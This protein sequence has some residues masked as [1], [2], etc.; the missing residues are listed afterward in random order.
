MLFSGLN[1]TSPGPALLLGTNGSPGNPGLVG[2]SGVMG[3]T[4]LQGKMILS[5]YTEFRII[6]IL[7][8]TLK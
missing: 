6:I 3:M 8:F 1:L 7:R 2:A 4:A 5:Y